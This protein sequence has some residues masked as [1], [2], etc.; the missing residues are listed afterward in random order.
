MKRRQ[1]IQTAGAATALCAGVSVARFTPI[2]SSPKLASYDFG[3]IRGVL[4]LWRHKIFQAQPSFNRTPS[5]I[6][7]IGLS[8]RFV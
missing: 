8:V 7:V 2:E 3:K 5:Q 4:P 6:A 1:F